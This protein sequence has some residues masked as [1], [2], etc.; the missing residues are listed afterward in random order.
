MEIKNKDCKSQDFGL[1]SIIMPNY[2]S[3]RFIK[4]TIESVL[5]QT[6]NNW[7][8]IIV[9]DCSTDNSLEIIR[10]YTDNRIKLLQNQKNCG[11]ATARNNAIEMAEGRWI[12]FLDSDDLWTPEKLSKQIAY[13]IENEIAFTYTDYDVVDE[14]NNIITTFIPKLNICTYTDILK[15]NYIGCLTVVYDSYK[16]GKV[17]MP[18]DAT[19][20]EDFA[21][22]LSIL[23]SGE[24]AHCLH[25][26]LSKYKVHSKSV[27]SNKFKMMKYQWLVYRKIEKLSL[28]KSLYYM[29]HWAIWGV[30]KYR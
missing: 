13:M 15:H 5:A 20:R 4:E 26:C 24:R 3:A 11:A 12:A 28:C 7:E 18:I 2:N 23:K 22:W 27:S 17:L 10:E 21:C 8:L 1:V 29:A 14:Q 19:K 16:L 25:E 30:L 6:Y 9:D